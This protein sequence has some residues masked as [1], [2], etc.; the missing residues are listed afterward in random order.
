MVW[1]VL[2]GNLLN[3]VFDDANTVN[4]PLP[5]N[6]FT[7]SAAFTEVTKV[8]WSLEPTSTSATSVI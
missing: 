3:A 1:I 7:K 5:F 8:V 6:V 4:R 2:F